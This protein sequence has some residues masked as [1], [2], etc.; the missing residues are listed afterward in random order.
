MSDLETTIRERLES[1][2]LLNEPEAAAVLDLAARLS[3]E[4][5]R[6]A[7]AAMLHAQLGSR[8][9]DLRKLAPTEVV[10]DDIDDIQQQR[11]KRLRAAGMS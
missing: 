9:A 11:E 6:P 10:A 4:E 2:N 7:A 3:V 8:L 5:L 1:W